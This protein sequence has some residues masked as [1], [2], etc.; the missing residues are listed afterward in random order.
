M[1]VRTRRNGLISVLGLAMA[2]AAFSAGVAQAA[3]RKVVI[4]NF[5]ASW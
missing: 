1:N 4:E 2:A 5:T 3:D